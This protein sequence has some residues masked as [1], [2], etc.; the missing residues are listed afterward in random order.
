MTR[1]ITR[2][3]IYRGRRFSPE[4]IALCVRWY[5]TYRLSYRDL[6]AMIAER[7]IVVSHTT[8]MRWVFQYVPEY[9]H[10]GSTAIGMAG[11]GRRFLLGPSRTCRSVALGRDTRP[12]VSCWRRAWIRRSRKES[13]DVSREGGDGL[14][15]GTQI[16]LLKL[17][18]G[19]CRD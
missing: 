19:A 16:G 18:T 9:E 6:A 14:V 1:R 10:I 15:E 12:P 7:E 3:P 17:R 2:D 11:S 8:I 5:I 13:C 4:V